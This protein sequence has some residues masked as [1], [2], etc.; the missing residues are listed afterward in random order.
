V[1]KKDMRALVDV[2]VGRTEALLD[3]LLRL[4]FELHNRKPKTRGRPT[5]VTVTPEI[6]AR[7]FALHAQFP[8]LPQHE[9]G[10]LAGVQQGRVSETLAG[11]RT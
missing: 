8:S 7:I 11:K 1:T 3:D 4:R 6:E 5:S 10:R 2:L 9:I